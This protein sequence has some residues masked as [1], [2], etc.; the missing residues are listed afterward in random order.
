M[1]ALENPGCYQKV[2][3]GIEDFVRDFEIAYS[4]SYPAALMVGS[5]QFAGLKV[6]EL[7]SK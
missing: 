2:L 3:K 4:I 7:F 5:Y 6:E 1:V